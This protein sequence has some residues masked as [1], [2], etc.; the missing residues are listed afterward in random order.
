[1]DETSIKVAYTKKLNKLNFS[2]LISVA[3]DSNVNIKTILNAHAYLFDEKVECGS[4]KAILT[5]RLGLKVL[6]IDTDGISNT[7]TDTQAI[8]ENIIDSAIT[9]DSLIN[10][11]NQV[12]VTNIISSDGVLK[13][14]CDVSITPVMYFN[15]PLINRCEQNENSVLK[16][17]EVQTI[18]ISN[19][20]NSNFEYTT[21]FETKDTISKILCIDTYFAPANIEAKEGSIYVEGKL[22][23]DLLY[24]TNENDK[25]TKKCLRDT[26]NLTTEIPAENISV[27]SIL[28]L[29]F[30]IDKS[31]ENITTEIEDD[32]SI[33]TI[34]NS[35]KVCGVS[36]KSVNIELVDDVFNTKNELELNTSERDFM[37]ANKSYYFQ[38]KIF[39]EIALSDKEPAID[40][41]I[42]NLNITPEIT[43]SYI[44]NG[45]LHFEGIISSHLCFIDEN[46][47]CIH[48]QIELPFV[49]NSK[50]EMEELL[51]THAQID[52]LDCKVKVKR[53]TIVEFEYDVEICLNVYSKERKKMIDGISIGKEFNLGGY[54]YQI[55]LAK[56]GE[57]MWELCKRIKISPEKLTQT[58]KNLPPV[59]NGGERIIIKR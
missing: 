31:K 41:V 23:T 47:E 55:Y 4:G 27:D 8:S 16:K 45:T 29:S 26:F 52:M 22:H 36:L 51:D 24:E 20:I 59:M 10:I 1:M 25:P 38:E 54:D 40:D 7:L 49:L 21:N 9:S 39:G 18:S 57:T 32:N 11:N 42:S 43:N 35:I 2:S 34:V 17:S 6:Y 15:L 46:Q 5:G 37:H 28:D 14:N 44:K 19:F 48:K 50:V 56:Q 33:I 13:V 30:K 3:I 58:N 53:G 12:L